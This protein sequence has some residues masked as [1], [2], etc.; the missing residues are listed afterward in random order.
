MKIFLITFLVILVLPTVFA[1][2]VHLYLFY[3]SKCPHCG[4]EKEF[5][6]A[7]QEQV[8]ELIVHEKEIGIKENLVL[9]AEMAYMYGKKTNSVPATIIDDQY[10]AGFG[11]DLQ[12]ILIQKILRAIMDNYANLHGLEIQTKLHLVV[13]KLAEEIKSIS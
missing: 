7:V 5:L 1:E 10:Y 8:P 3:S 12:N 9:W 2:D 13:F 6:K 11:S 4:A